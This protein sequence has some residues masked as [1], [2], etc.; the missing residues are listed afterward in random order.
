MCRDEGFCVSTGLAG[1]Y[2]IKNAAGA[3]KASA[4]V[5]S[6]GW[7]GG[8]LLVA[9]PPYGE[10]ADLIREIPLAILANWKITCTRH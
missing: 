4:D 9:V 2:S 7:S 3:V 8:L 5:V 10:G 1:A 6:V